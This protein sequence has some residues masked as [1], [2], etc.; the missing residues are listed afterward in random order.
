MIRT[1]KSYDSLPNFSAADCLTVLG[2]K[3]SAPAMPRPHL[4]RRWQVGRNQWVACPCRVAPRSHPRGLAP[5]YIDLMNQSKSRGAFFGRPRRV[6]PTALLPDRPVNP[7]KLA[8][9]WSVVASAPPSLPTPRRASSRARRPQA[10]WITDEDVRQCSKAE[11]DLID[12]LIFRGSKGV[13]AGHL[14]RA[15]VT[16][17]YVKG[18][19]AAA[20]QPWLLG[21]SCAP[22]RARVLQGPDQRE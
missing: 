16:S 3:S 21:H 8:H 11:K 2:V 20:R 4:T 12:V 6:D 7:D 10:G 15:V 17:L 14:D 9:W 19:V 22:A 1:E 13:M 5:R 18:E